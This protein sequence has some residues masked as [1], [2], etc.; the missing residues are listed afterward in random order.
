[1]LMP[2]TVFIGLG[3]NLGNSLHEIETAC[4]DIA[5]HPDF[6]LTKVSYWYR[7]KAVGP[8]EQP[9]YINGAVRAL[10]QLSPHQVLNALQTIEQQHHR[11]RDIRWGPRTL[12]LDILLYDKLIIEDEV[13]TI[14]HKQITH[15][16]FVLQPLLD[17]DND[18]DLPDGRK[19]IDLLHIIGINDL[20]RVGES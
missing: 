11:V 3:S 17:L 12:D 5:N 2:H 10:T 4:Q 1:M 7:S 19:V 15:R 14:P 6:A 16:N 18:L 20:H 13:L 9:D 8:G